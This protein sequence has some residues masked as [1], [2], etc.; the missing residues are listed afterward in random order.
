MDKIT[1]KSILP[2]KFQYL[3]KVK[4][5]TKDK[6]NKRFFSSSFYKTMTCKT[7]LFYKPISKIINI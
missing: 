5:N 6:K 4:L 3:K 2:I 7:W 1:N